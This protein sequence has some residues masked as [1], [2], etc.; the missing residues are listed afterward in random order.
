M[1][2]NKIISHIITE[3]FAIETQQMVLFSIFL[4]CET[5]L[6]PY[7]WSSIPRAKYLYVERYG[8]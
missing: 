3:G 4:R 2:K 7:T 5:L 8:F 6:N 1:L